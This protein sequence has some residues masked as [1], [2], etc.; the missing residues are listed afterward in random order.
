MQ[1][2]NRKVQIFNMVLV[3]ALMLGGVV[4]APATAQAQEGQNR[5]FLP[6]VNSS[7]V[8]STE[9][10]LGKGNP[11]ESIPEVI[12]AGSCYRI[13]PSLNIRKESYRCPNCRFD[14]LLVKWPVRQGWYLDLRPQDTWA[15]YFKENMLYG[16]WWEASNNQWVTFGSAQRWVPP[17][18]YPRPRWTKKKISGTDL[19]SFNTSFK[20]YACLAY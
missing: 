7:I 16:Q 17:Y 12:A 20:S 1:T 2:H 4:I 18:S 10:S 9:P 8:A 3:L 19:G 5:V 14:D 13:W 6:L 15:T 11:N